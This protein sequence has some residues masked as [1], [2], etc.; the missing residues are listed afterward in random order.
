MIT[1]IILLIG[2][3]FGIF[4]SFLWYKQ[5]NG[6][7]LKTLLLHN[8]KIAQ[9]I[10]YAATLRDHETGL[11]NF[12]VAY[13]TAYFCEVLNLEKSEIQSIM[14]GAY[15]HDIGKIGIS[16]TIL[17]KSASLDDDEWKI[18]Q[19]HSQLGKKLAMNIEWFEDALPV[20]L[21][22]HEHYDGTGYPE[23]LKAK[24]I[25]YQARIFA[26]VDVFDALISKRPYKKA[27]SL[28]DSLEIIREKKGTHFDPD[29]VDIFVLNAPQF[30]HSI[31]NKSEDAMKKMLIKKRDS[32][33]GLYS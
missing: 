10:G 5:K 2:F 6:E 3:L 20:I 11:H 22:H 31:H 32:I 25:P 24:S 7:N 4:V 16:D 30:Y 17:L 13:M 23:G 27:F 14:K 28:E 26:I 29:L 12:R 8:M 21:Y 33:F 19:T 18:M 15:L 1:I 9:A